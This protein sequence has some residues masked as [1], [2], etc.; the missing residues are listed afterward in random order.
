MRRASRPGA[1]R[2]SGRSPRQ[3]R[4]PLRAVRD[5]PRGE[6]VAGRRGVAPPHRP[7]RGSR[8]RPGPR[9]RRRPSPV[10]ASSSS[11][12]HATGPGTKT[13]P[14]RASITGNAPSPPCP[15]RLERRDP[16]CADSERHPQPT[17]NREADP[18]GGE[19]SGPGPDRERVD[20]GR[21]VTGLPQKLV[22]V[23][24][25]RSGHRPALTEQLPV[26]DEGTGGDCGGRVEG[27]DQHLDARAV[28]RVGSQMV[29][30]TGRTGRSLIKPL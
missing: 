15:E 29:V 16:G 23:D 13:S 1:A 3:A 8:D 9:P 20:V 2:R 5:E 30:R 24:E 7:A 21:R 18:G 12:R 27:K 10:R 25:Q 14:R 17:R 6:R 28:V 19:A 4:R 11:G 26:A 22:E